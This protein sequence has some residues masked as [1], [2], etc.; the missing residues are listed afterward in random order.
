M[1]KYYAIYKF[2]LKKVLLFRKVM[3]ERGVEVLVAETPLEM[4][5]RRKR[6]IHIQ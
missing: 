1:D 5:M 6:L 4:T 2:S 3:K